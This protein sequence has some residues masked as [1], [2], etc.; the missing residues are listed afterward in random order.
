MASLG[1]G[2]RVGHW[3]NQQGNSGCTVVLPPAGNVSSCDI[4]GSSPS[5]REVEHL[6]PDRRLTEIHAVLMT[7]GSAFGLAAAEGVVSS[8][9]EQGI[10]YATPIGPIP[11]VPGAVVFDLGTADP[12]ARPGAAAGRSACE[13]AREDDIDTGRIGAGTGATVGKWAGREFSSPGG[14]GIAGIEEAGASVAAIAVVNSIG[15]VVAADGSVIAGT[16]SPAPEFILP[17]RQDRESAEPFPSNTVLATVVT[18][19]TLD[20]RDVRWLASRGS[21]GI[22]QSVRPAHTRYDGDVVFAIAAPGP[23]V[24]IDLLGYLATRAVAGAV[25]SAVGG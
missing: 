12:A 11:I 8:L 2:F 10:G 3:T 9:E 18:S 14:V 16:T 6:H 17:V 19:A 5:S 22:A 15:D 25:R 23:E 4:R 1:F 7:G 24:S 13:D 21:D 20:K